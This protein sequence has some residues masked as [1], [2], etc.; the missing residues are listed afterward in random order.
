MVVLTAGADE[1]FE[2]VEVDS[3]GLDDLGISVGVTMTV[4]VAPVWMH[5]QNTEADDEGSA[6]RVEKR[7]L[8]ALHGLTV[9]GSSQ[10][11]PVWAALLPI[12]PSRWAGSNG[13]RDG[14]SREL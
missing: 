11:F 7:A 12:S 1:G 8:S 10:S 14:R 4:F 9:I 3:A 6:W 2:D 5:E 13:C